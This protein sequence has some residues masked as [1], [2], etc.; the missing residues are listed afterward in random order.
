MSGPV[1]S[2][3]TAVAGMVE[4][5]PDC[6]VLSSMKIFEYVAKQ[7]IKSMGRDNEG[8]MDFL[9]SQ[10]DRG[11]TEEVILSFTWEFASLGLSL[12]IS[13]PEVFRIMFDLTYAPV[14]KEKWSFAHASGLAIPSAQHDHSYSTQ[15]K[16]W[17]MIFL[18]FAQ[19]Y[20]KQ[21]YNTLVG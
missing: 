20:N 2:A 15:E 9:I 11:V 19:R 3:H 4:M 5:M 16:L 21:H 17:D 8:L 12:G 18:E 14:D 13:Q 7:V 6:S 1:G 10:K